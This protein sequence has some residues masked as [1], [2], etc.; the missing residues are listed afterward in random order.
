MCSPGGVEADM[1]FKPATCAHTARG[2]FRVK[3]CECGMLFGAYKR[4][5]R[6]CG[7]DCPSFKHHMRSMSLDR[8][9]DRGLAKYWTQER[10]I[11][12]V[13]RWTARTG[14]PPKAEQ[15]RS[16]TPPSF[17]IGTRSRPSGRYVAR[18]FGSWSAA[19]DAAGVEQNRHSPP[20]TYCKHG[21]LLS[22]TAVT[23]QDG[24]RFCGE[25]ERARQRER[26]RS[27][28]RHCRHGKLGRPRIDLTGQRFGRLRA[29]QSV[30]CDR[31]G[32]VLWICECDCGAVTTVAGADLRAGKKKSCGCLRRTNELA[33]PA[34]H[35]A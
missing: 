4:D 11:R 1:T 7:R 26:R 3:R 16:K 33:A 19:L 23:R 17:G 29:I 27:G 13:Q 18:V 31:Y 28:P 8:L 12:A 21:H 2:G 20:R 6:F 32:H 9:D 10:I 35:A 22:K 5:K 25:C 14:E 30:G 24:S 34:D 15:W